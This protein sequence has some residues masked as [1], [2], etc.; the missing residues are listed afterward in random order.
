MTLSPRFWRDRAWWMRWLAPVGALVV[1]V[2]IT[3]R[4]HLHYLYPYATPVSNDEGYISAFAIRLIRGHWLPYVDAISQ[5]GPV[6]Y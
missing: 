5:R 1:S 6:L 3:V 4:A 2:L